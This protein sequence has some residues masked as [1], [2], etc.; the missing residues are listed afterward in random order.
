MIINNLISMSV[1][2]TAFVALLLTV[3]LGQPVFAQSDTTLVNGIVFNPK[4]EVLPG[5]LIRIGDKVSSPSD[6]Q[7]A[8]TF[9]LEP[10]IW[11]VAVQ[12]PG[13]DWVAV[14]RLDTAGAESIELL[15]NFTPTGIVLDVEGARLKSDNPQATDIQAEPGQV[16]LPPGTLKGTVVGVEDGKPVEG[17]R[18]LIRG[19]ADELVTD[20]KGRFTLTL[21][22]GPYDI[23]ILHRSFTTLN[24]RGFKI[25]PEQEKKEKF[26][27]T[28]SGMELDEF[29]ISAP[30][31]EGQTTA[32][33]EERKNSNAAMDLIGAEQFSKSGD[34]SAASALR[35]V[36]G[37]TLVDGKY[38][39]VRGM[40]DR[41]SSVRLNGS[42]LPSPE[43]Q[44]RVVPLDM[45][46]TSV[47]ESIVVQKTFAA[48]MPADFGGGTVMLRTRTFPSDFS[49]DVSLSTGYDSET[50]R[51]DGLRYPGGSR[52]W[53][54]M[55]DGTR[56]LS[57]ELQAA[58]DGKELSKK[59][60]FGRGNYTAEELEVIGESLNNNY[61]VLPLADENPK[62]GIEVE[63]G[64]GF[65]I[66]DVAFGYRLTLMYSN[67]TQS[68]F[69]TLKSYAIEDGALVAKDDY[70]L[71]K[72]V[73]GINLGGFFTTGVEIGDE[74]EIKFTSFI[75]R[76]TDNTTRLK[77]GWYD[78]YATDIQQ[79]LLSFEERQLGFYQLVGEHSLPGIEGW[80]L[81][82]MYAYSTA[83]RNE[84]DRRQYR[85]DLSS[86]GNFL[87][88]DRPEGNNRSWSEVFDKNHDASF[89]MTIPVE[90]NE[91]F[92]P[93][94]KL[95]AALSRKNRVFDMRRF[96]YFNSSPD[97]ALTILEPDE[98]FVPEN[99]GTDGFQ[100]VELTR[101]TDNYAGHHYITSGFLAA[102]LPIFDWALVTAGVRIEKSDMFVETFELFGDEIV[103]TTLND[104]DILPAFAATWFLNEDMQVRAGV[105]KTVN[106]P[107]LRELSP[108][109][110]DNDE[111][112]FTETGNPDIISAGI[113][114]VDLRWEWYLNMDEW[115]TI[116]GFYKSFSNPI[117]DVEVP[118]ATPQ[119]TF[120]NMLGAT[121]FG[122][123]IEGRKSLDFVSKYL[124]DVY[125][126]ANAAFIQSQIS[127]DTDGETVI[128]VTNPE[129]KLQGQS[130]Y[131]LNVQLEYDNPDIGTM[132]ALLYNSY[133]AR[134]TTAGAT[135]Q[136]DQF[137]E[138]AHLLDLVFSQK[139][140]G[141]FK[142]KAK[143]QNLLN[144][145]IA[146]TKDGNDVKT[147]HKGVAVS[148]GL[149]YSY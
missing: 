75:N 36:V 123:E 41:Y 68:R 129:R 49:F 83:D 58:T 52:D 47:I 85:Y 31:I 88:S 144:A 60:R 20:K 19:L 38:I 118:G 57:P 90:F 61:R 77:S 10:G 7:G 13:S 97:P 46:P 84:P 106:R 91:E 102:D 92:I 8:F 143:G 78:D 107:N 131:M 32:L 26:E 136:P 99:I 94:V 89:L 27:L 124:R 25:E 119:K 3:L 24:K 149:S 104:L 87:M 37:L 34:S 71:L 67:E 142:F 80:E 21:P 14:T 135:G 108:Q 103:P 133:G 17:A 93:K 111:S 147:T 16:I 51:L 120:L 74:H 63:V 122:I 148:M 101:P 1:R 137:E 115:L 30:R 54:G 116:G 62:M 121:N 125:F 18:V 64:D 100:L 109:A 42:S 138:T 53:L 130:P 82:W 128:D 72:T 105:G 6:E 29:T 44:K 59:D 35:R 69:Q 98:L 43:S 96:K 45:F 56:A 40:G 70:E 134:I 9:Q 117:E 76:L 113:L 146:E 114:N 5:V 141:G 81:S 95:G 22:G 23:S 140:G 79:T 28:P 112:G 48:D 110:F 127:I 39:F 2:S 12:A 11:D 145:K 15:I 132:V 86:E 4:G 66:G 50:Y 139:L 65:E 55:D 73:N 33:V 126:T